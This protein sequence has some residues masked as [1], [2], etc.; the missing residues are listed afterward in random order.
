MHGD[1]TGQLP[2]SQGTAGDGAEIQP[3]EEA[4]QEGSPDEES[5]IIK[6]PP[7]VKRSGK[8]LTE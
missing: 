7:R 4:K 5:I 2:Y 8:K 3:P 1:F 6:R